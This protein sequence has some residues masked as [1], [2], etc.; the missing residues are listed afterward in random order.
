[1]NKGELQQAKAYIDRMN[2]SS[3]GSNDTFREFYL[4]IFNIHYYQKLNKKDS[5][6]YETEKALQFAQNIGSKSLEANYLAE[7]ARLLKDKNMEQA[8]SRL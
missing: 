6:L 2:I 4:H 3:K 5:V 1:V 8:H 7:K